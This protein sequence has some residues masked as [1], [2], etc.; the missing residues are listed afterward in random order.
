M[1]QLIYAHRGASQR[2]AE[3]T[4]AA[5]LQAIADGADGVECDIHLTRDLK[6][7]C[8]HD[9]TLDRTSNGTGSVADH[10]LRQ[11]RDLD[12]CSWKGATIPPEY[13]GILDQFL[14]LAD[15]IRILRAAGRPI[16]LAIEC[17]HPSPFGHRLEEQLL[18]F[19]MAEGWDP[20]NSVLDNITISFMSF[21]PDSVKRLLEQVPDHFVCQ[22]VAD[23]DPLAIRRQF[24]FSRITAAAVLRVM[25]AAAAEA[26]ELI[27]THRVGL[28]GPGID[29]VKVHRDDVER[30]LARGVRFRVWTVDDPADIELCRELGIQEI[31]TNVPA[32]TAARL[33]L[34]PQPA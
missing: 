31:T 20:E 22:L 1:R 17:K 27:R 4:R 30:L 26:E 19:L 21:S 7:V 11:L 34:Q 8:L 3:H 9:A 2:F 15:L 10:T 14:T 28:A 6:L 29:Y 16:G 33:A 13:G 32:E 12:F 25:R 5:Y 24:Q 18:G 23:V